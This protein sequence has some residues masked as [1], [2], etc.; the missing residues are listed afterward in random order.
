MV[1]RKLLKSKPREILFS[2]E[3]NFEKPGVI[4]ISRLLSFETHV[5]SLCNG[6]LVFHRQ[7]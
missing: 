6:H 2:L 4:K 7:S 3:H 1:Q 5:E